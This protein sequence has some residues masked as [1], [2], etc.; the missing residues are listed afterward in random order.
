MEVSYQHEFTGI[1]QVEEN[2][3]FFLEQTG[4]PLFFYSQVTIH[5]RESTNRAGFSQHARSC[6][7]ASQNRRD[8]PAASNAADRHGCKLK[9]NSFK[10]SAAPQAELSPPEKGGNSEK[11][12][13]SEVSTLWHYLPSNIDHL[14]CK[15]CCH[16]LLAKRSLN[17]KRTRYSAFAW[18]VSD[19]RMP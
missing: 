5:I 11:R 2:P 6:P 17:L 16:L 14:I 15:R 1:Y 9:A 3:I 7:R 12:A 8:E 13:G 10:G 18:L 4:P 19:T